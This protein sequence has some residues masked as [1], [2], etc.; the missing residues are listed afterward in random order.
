MH[1][2]EYE[3]AWRK[4]IVDLVLKDARLELDPYYFTAHY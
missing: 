1:S 4:P 2:R 3:H